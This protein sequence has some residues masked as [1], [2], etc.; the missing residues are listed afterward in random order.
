MKP[1][2]LIAGL[3]TSTILVG[4]LTLAPHALAEPTTPTPEPTPVPAS[5]YSYAAIGDSATVGGSWFAPLG[6]L[7]GRNRVDYPNVLANNTGLQLNETACYDAT[8]SNYQRTRPAGILNSPNP[9]QVKAIDK[10]TRMVTIQ[11]GLRDIVG[12]GTNSLLTKCV[13][14][15]GK[16]YTSMLSGQPTELTG[17]PCRDAYGKATLKKFDGLQA[18]L[19]AIYANTNTAP[20][21]KPTTTP[22]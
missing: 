4:S 18:R 17:S 10:N 2:R 5:P 15:W 9:P 8:T 1:S 20:S 13:S 11:L 16:E 22:K 12:D 7:C 14:A 6:D 21:A 19:A 3:T